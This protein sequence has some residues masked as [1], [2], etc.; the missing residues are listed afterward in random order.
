MSIFS[1]GNYFCGFK[2]LFSRKLHMNSKI[3]QFSRKIKIK[4]E[5]KVFCFPFYFMTIGTIL[6]N[7]I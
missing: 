5:S 4:K 3:D 6:W 1:S 7:I 2:N